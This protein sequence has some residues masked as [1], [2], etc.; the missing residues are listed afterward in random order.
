MSSSTVHNAIITRFSNQGIPGTV[1]GTK[2][3]TRAQKE[4]GDQIDK[5]GAKARGT[6]KEVGALDQ[7]LKTMG[8]FRWLSYAGFATVATGIGAMTREALGFEDAMAKVH[9]VNK[10]EFAASPGLFNK[11]WRETLDIAQEYRSTGAEAAD[12]LYQIAA[13]GVKASDSMTVLRSS[14]N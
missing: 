1:S 14:L 7:S 13:A 4:L 5:T 10:E 3:V 12:A 9:A 6:A 8:A 11:T 2:Q